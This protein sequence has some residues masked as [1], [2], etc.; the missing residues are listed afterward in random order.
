MENL[1]G[2]LDVFVSKFRPMKYTI[3]GREEKTIMKIIVHVDTNKARC[4][5]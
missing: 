2:D 1:S 4:L 3:S 5:P